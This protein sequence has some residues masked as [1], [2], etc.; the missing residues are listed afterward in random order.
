MST[1]KPDAEGQ[2]SADAEQGEEI[3][4]VVGTVQVPLRPK[5]TGPPPIPPPPAQRPVEP[6]APAQAGVNAEGIRPW[7]T[8]DGHLAE[9]GMSYIHRVYDRNLR[10]EAAMKVLKAEFDA[11]SLSRHRFLEEAQITG[12]LDH[13][14][15]PPVYDL[16][17][18]DERH[19]H[20]TMK[21][22]DGQTLG[23]ILA[24]LYPAGLGDRE[25]EDLLKI[26]VKVCD[27]VSFA[28]SRGVIH[29][30]L[31][32]ANIMVGTYGQVL[33]MDWG[34]AF[35]LPMLEGV[36]VKLLRDPAAKTLDPPDTAI[37]TA[38]YLSPEQA[39]AW[40]DKIDQ[41]TD[42]YGLGGVLY[43][44]LTYKAPHDCPDIVQS[45]MKAQTGEV[46]HPQELAPTKIPPELCRIAMRA[47]APKSEDRYATVRE[48]QEDV[49]AALR[50]GWWFG[51]ETFPVGTVVVREGDP[52]D[53]AY[54]IRSGVC[55]VFRIEGG[56]RVFLRKMGSGDTFGETAIF[57]KQ[58]RSASV[59]VTEEM[60]A[61]VVTPESFEQAMGQSSWMRPFIRAVAE[62]FTEADARLSYLRDTE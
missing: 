30:D 19:V 31:K 36:G 40:T 35:V 21:L 45:V 22:V 15:I 50:D 32:S 57:T 58:T 54:I 48:L 23:D 37:G 41:R 12:Q 10:R 59:E 29:R 27:A 20:F 6:P 7:L 33:V 1:Q 9:G 46:A 4:V 2:T 28:H 39:N 52:A 62:R 51:T 42:V 11:D 55:E 13:P 34:C 61:T 8:D 18:D 26:F 16:W 17:V 44:I 25:L 3:P 38:A 43:E 56:K 14:N 49:E 47:L 53:A 60:T 5:K 24:T